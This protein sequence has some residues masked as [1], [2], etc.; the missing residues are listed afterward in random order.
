MLGNPNTPQGERSL[1]DTEKESEEEGAAAGAAEEVWMEVVSGKG[2]GRWGAWLRLG[3]CPA[4]LDRG[5][6]PPSWHPRGGWD[7]GRPVGRAAGPRWSPTNFARRKA[8]AALA[9]EGP[10]WVGEPAVPRLAPCRLAAS[11]PAHP[12]PSSPPARPRWAPRLLLFLPVQP[13]RCPRRASAGR[14]RP[15]G[16]GH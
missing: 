15:S 6:L 2:H 14:M 10:A 1:E 8:P 11:L 7:H 5:K 12:V 4:G 9:L 16:G 3:L 13:S